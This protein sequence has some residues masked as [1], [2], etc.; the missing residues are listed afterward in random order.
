M[1][2]NFDSDQQIISSGFTLEWRC[3]SKTSKDFCN[4]A[5]FNSKVLEAIPAAFQ[6][7]KEKY[8]KTGRMIGM[9]KNNSIKSFLK[10]GLSNFRFNFK[11]LSIHNLYIYE[12]TYFRPASS[13][14]PKKNANVE[15]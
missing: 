4:S 3:A 1:L 14:R 8:T 13:E 10:L 6:N 5:E 2:I 7:D 15:F 12:N 11:F 9:Y